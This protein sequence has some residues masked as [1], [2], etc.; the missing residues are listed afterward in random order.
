VIAVLAAGDDKQ[1]TD[2][3]GIPEGAATIEALRILKGQT[4]AAFGTVKISQRYFFH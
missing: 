1:C 3:E 2:V 4:L